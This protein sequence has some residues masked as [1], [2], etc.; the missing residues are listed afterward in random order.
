MSPRI[1]LTFCSTLSLLAGS[2]PSAFAEEIN[3]KAARVLEPLSKRPGSGPLFERFVNAWLDTGTLES[4]GKF[5]TARV[6][7]DPSPA[8]RMLLA[9]FYSRQGEPVKAL[10][11]FRAALET[12]PG[13]ADIWYQKALLESRTLDFDAAAASLAKCLAAKPAGELAVQAAQLLGRV[14]AR[15][16]HMEEALKT[17]Q[18]LMLARPEDEA[19][20]EDILELQIAESLWPAA[21]ETAAKL[22]EITRDPYQRVIRRM[23]L[24]DVHDR[25]GQREKALETFAACLDDTG[26]GSWLEK[27]ILGQM[28]KLFRRE[29][30]LSGLREYF[31]GLV[32]KHR[33]RP[34]LQRARARLLM[35]SG[36]HAEAIAAGRE[37]LALLPGDRA[38]REEFISLLTGA[39]RTEEAIPQVEQLL[40]QTPGD[41]ELRLTLAELKFAAKDQTG[42]LQTI[43]EC[44]AQAGAPE[45]LPMR[46]AGILDRN[47]RTEEAVETL[48]RA[49]ER[50]PDQPEMR[51]MMA[52]LLHKAGKAP[53]AVAEWEK[54]AAGGSLPA[55]QQTARAMQAHGAGDEA[56]KLML[57]AAPGAA[58]D[59]V[60]LTQLCTF[61][62][63][64]ERAAQVMPQA[65]QLVELARSAPDLSSALDMTLRLVR[66]AG[67][68]ASLTE[69]LRQSA[70]SAQSFC[71]L[72]ALQESARDTAG[73][74]ASLEKARTLSPGLALSEMVRLWT[75]RGDFG[76]AAAA[77]EN[78]FNSPD[79]RQGHVAEMIASLHQRAGNM[80]AALQWTQ[81]WR[82]LLPGSP[83]PVLSEARMLEAAG[84][85]DD[86]FSLLRS[87]AG[88]FENNSDIRARLASMSLE[89]GRTADALRLYSTLYEEAQDLPAKMRW[90]QQWG[91]A[92]LSAG[93]LEELITQFEDRRRENRESPAP[94]LALAELHRVADNYE[95]RRK[96]LT[97]AARLKPDD[98]EIA[99]EI[100]R[101]E[102][103]EENDD[104]AMQTLRPLVAKDSTGRAAA[105]LSEILLRNGREEEGLKLLQDSTT[106]TAASVEATAL[107]LARRGDDAAALAFLE[108]HLA[109][110][111]GDWRLGWLA[112]LLEYRADRHESAAARL[113]TLTSV[114]TPLTRPGTS[115]PSA[116]LGKSYDELVV[117]TMPGSVQRFFRLLAAA[118]IFQQNNGR[119]SVFSFLPW[120]LEELH[121]RSA[122]LLVEL[123]KDAAPE[124]RA[125]W[126]AELEQRGFPAAKLLPELPSMRRFMVNDRGESLQ[127]LLKA[128]PDS[129]ELLAL[130]ALNSAYRNWQ[131]PADAALAEKAWTVFG[132]TAPQAALFLAIPGGGRQE[133]PL[134]WE[135]EMLAA[136]AAVD[137]A[138]PLLMLAAVRSLGLAAEEEN[139]AVKH[140]MSQSWYREILMHLQRWQRLQDAAGSVSGFGAD[141]REY[142]FHGL[143]VK[144]AAAAD[145]KELAAL[146]DAEW[147]WQSAQPV[148]AYSSG[149]E[150][151]A[152]PVGFPPDFLPGLSDAL[153]SFI[154]K[155]LKPETAAKLAPE[156]KEPVLRLLTLARVPGG[157]A[158]AALTEFQQQ[159][160]GAAMPFV[161]AAAWAE[162]QGDYAAAAEQAKRALF[163][164]VSQE[165]RR[166]LDGALAWWASKKG[167]PGDPL[168]AAGRE[169]VLRLRRDAT[170]EERRIELAGL[171]DQLG[172]S[173]EADR[174]MR[175][176]EAVEGLVSGTPMERAE[177][178]LL[179]GDR[180]AALPLLMAEIRTWTRQLLS[181]GGQMPGRDLLAEWRTRVQVHGLMPEIMAALLPENA[182]A[183]QQAEFAAACQLTGD[184]AK[185]REYYT[186]AV[187]AGARRKVPQ[188]L[189]NLI[190]KD[191][192][193]RAIALLKDIPDAWS[194]PV[195]RGLLT[196]ALNAEN[197]R[198]AVSSQL[199]F[200]EFLTKLIT[201]MP[202]DSGAAFP[203]R[204][205]LGTLGAEAFEGSLYLITEVTE[206]SELRAQRTTP[207][208]EEEKQRVETLVKQRTAAYEAVCRQLLTKPGC[209]LQAWQML[210]ELW[211]VT[212]RKPEAV[213][214][215]GMSALVAELKA[216][217]SGKRKA[218]RQE[219]SEV[220]GV[221]ELLMQDAAT[222]GLTAEFARDVVPAV[223]AAHSPLA[224]EKMLD[225]WPLYEA[226]PEQFAAVA[227]ERLTKD[228]EDAWEAIVGA[229]SH[230]RCGTELSADLKAAIL[231]EAKEEAGAAAAEFSSWCVHLSTAKG[232]PEAGEFFQSVL[233]ELAGPREG[234]AERMKSSD[235]EAPFA[236]IQTLLEGTSSAEGWAPATLRWVRDELQPFLPAEKLNEL[237]GALSDSAVSGPLT[238]AL[239]RK[240]HAAA[241]TLLDSVTLT[242]DLAGFY[243][244][245]DIALDAAGA[246]RSQLNDPAMREALGFGGDPA[247]LTFGRLYLLSI[248][249]GWV[250]G[251]CEALAPW[252]ARIEALPEPSRSRV[253]EQLRRVKGM[254]SDTITPAGRE[255]HAWLYA[256]DLK[257][258]QESL[259]T[260][261][262]DFLR[263]AADGSIPDGDELSSR[264]SPLLQQMVQ[265]LDPRGRE[266]MLAA[267]KAA[268]AMNDDAAGGQLVETVMEY[269]SDYRE[270]PSPRSAAWLLSLLATALQQGM[271]PGDLYDWELGH[272]AQG[273]FGGEDDSA[274]GSLSRMAALLA[275]ALQPGE[276]RLIMPWVLSR[277][278]GDLGDSATAFREGFAWIKGPGQ[279]IPNKELLTEMEMAL[280]L[281]APA[282]D[283][284]PAAPLPPAQQHY[285]TLL[286][287]ASL[288]PA[289]RT[290]IG[291]SLIDLM[292]AD[293]APEFL[294]ECARL[295]QQSLTERLPVE[296]DTEAQILFHLAELPADRRDA[297]LIKSL[298]PLSTLARI[299]TDTNGY[300]I[301][302]GLSALLHLALESGDEG[303]VSRLLEMEGSFPNRE[304]IILL[305]RHGR[306]ER[307]ATLLKDNPEALTLSGGPSGVWRNWDATLQAQVPAVL[308]GV[309]DPVTR[310]RALTLL[311][312]LETEDPA[313]AGVQPVAARLAAAAEG[314]AAV[315]WKSPAPRDATLADHFITASTPVPELLLPALEE[316]CARVPVSALP[317][318][319]DDERDTG[320]RLHAARLRRAVA[321]GNLEPLQTALAVLAPHPAI[322]D[323]AMDYV[324]SSLLDECFTAMLEG[325]HA[326]PPASRTAV[327]T[328]WR[329]FM[330]D[331]VCRHWPNEWDN[332]LLFGITL[333]AAA[334]ENAALA[335]WHQG[336]SATARAEI[337]G[338][339]ETLTLADVSLMVVPSTQPEA[340][341]TPEEK[342]AR[343]QAAFTALLTNPLAPLSGIDADDWYASLYKTAT[344]EDFLALETTLTTAR[345]AD[346]WLA[347]T[348]ARTHAQA[349]NWPAVLARA[350]AALAQSK[351]S[352]L[353][354]WAPLL[355]LKLQ[356]LEKTGQPVTPVLEAIK[357]WPT[358]PPA[359]S[360][361]KAPHLAAG[362]AARLL[363]R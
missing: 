92:A 194:E 222:A 201:A 175:Q 32:E 294:T 85:T 118:S 84:R 176:G 192:P 122:A 280:Q 329:E 44:E 266:V 251:M 317:F 207:V 202:E 74:T 256:E 120:D 8:N 351:P 200:A 20:R 71:L 39:G 261:V 179:D 52:S 272:A 187:A 226:P 238:L 359:Y 284:A 335:A 167:R 157:D 10:E 264:F 257:K 303:L 108:P 311:A 83:A 199:S 314:F 169:A 40:T 183:A 296:M 259:D 21:L 337:A 2:V 14:Q 206:G 99:M 212:D 12:N 58:S 184:L 260:L 93:R 297:A 301:M 227:R 59:P 320:S 126:M 360:S 323:D 35:E 363:A 233:T 91:E 291:A 275:P 245:G 336:L 115:T 249:Q 325:L 230:R 270:R 319:E 271:A 154:Q 109:K 16:G 231:A 42:A 50:K 48:R 308:D 223:R 37:L 287:D 29:E 346:D 361:N 3:E 45:G 61:A 7:A 102:S 254:I 255:F 248:A 193:D 309:T 142:V 70:A 224:A 191:E 144:H 322:D 82:R 38:V 152:A 182:T 334:G 247:S 147:R 1:L 324:R 216:G 128:S 282:D 339:L 269:L 114:T 80:E 241:R 190:V 64:A 132:R 180:K 219:E 19:L 123:A 217:R 338:T 236:V 125:A 13:S 279:A 104:A 100:A 165:V 188:L 281:Q 289:L 277:L 345:P 328:A 129:Q 33:H 112:A 136:A 240:D 155:E 186:K 106:L 295:L 164:P 95:G 288:S 172:L 43:R 72:A 234:R 333:H 293:P 27:E 214:A 68:T 127:R 46:L 302:G 124:Q 105:L 252:R 49:L 198:V 268:K 89:T 4:L 211:V 267:A 156:L 196:S 331:A 253:L 292:D 215:D 158:A 304:A 111:P 181:S 318:V 81:E 90:L 349:G 25:A 274:A 121:D 290:A 159:Q 146:L 34:G 276:A 327:C 221:V 283:D 134:P 262:K 88:R 96:A 30:D 242:G 143:A 232:Q 229:A 315:P 77:A 69:D 66:L 330:T 244:G 306:K 210:R 341:G 161:L 137:T 171:M 54:S 170:T 235:F 62:D 98:V 326:M 204:I 342:I 185:A 67:Q 160:P 357:A 65:R 189:C 310:Y 17:W 321:T 47:S 150:E 166:R 63:S 73:A 178:L 258:Q 28:E 76:Q 51:L 139:W 350:D 273:I 36:E 163:L 348:F 87:A 101:L 250:T 263:D 237:E 340:P 312:G 94:L 278:A 358:L 11:Q 56:W 355:E 299:R 107:S 203:V 140:G 131:E 119:Q 133:K 41:M 332:R 362:S 53:E 313:P 239:S 22:V 130:A 213:A 103:R 352:R 97:E 173:E 209:R 343:F 60:F 151:I 117:Q 57:A 149:D 300:T 24:G 148:V 138:P 354:A 228:G 141:L 110:W 145:I 79:G 298:L 135:Q 5:L 18:A 347:F 307:L 86:A 218:A 177:R 75:I 208:P 344:A 31:A 113:L 225:L 246:L 153:A 116:A 265:T 55:I 285:L 286:R 23:R 15:A 174:L 205:A 26:A 316:A 305:A 162:K 220:A 6:T 78:L 195:L 197:E 353:S 243:G 9:L 168:H 356:A